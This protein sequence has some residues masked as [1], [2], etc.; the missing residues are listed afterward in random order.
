[1]VSVFWAGNPEK[2]A[3][4]FTITA[5]PVSEEGLKVLARVM[6]AE[7]VAWRGDQLTLSTV[8]AQD[9]PRESR[10]HSIVLEL[11]QGSRQALV[12]S[13]QAPE[14]APHQFTA[15]EVMQTRLGTGSGEGDVT[16]SL[17]IVIF[18]AGTYGARKGYR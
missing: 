3:A 7:P 10:Q 11:D 5:R 18:P 6:K 14:L 16:G 4:A 2:E 17:G 12:V 13:A 1:M 15:V 9:D 8:T